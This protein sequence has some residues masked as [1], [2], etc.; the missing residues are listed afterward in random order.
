MKKLI[1]VLFALVLFSPAVCRADDGGG[2]DKK[3][4]TR[5]EVTVF[6]KKLVAVLDAMGLPPAGFAQEKDDFN[7][8]TE[9]YKDGKGK[10]NGSHASATRR[11][12]IKGVKDAEKGNKQLGVDYQKKMM[13][14]QAKGDY[15]AIMALSQEMQQKVGKTALSGVQAQEDKKLPIEVQVGLNDSA[16]QTIDPDMVVFEKP[17]VIAIKTQVGEEGDPKITISVYFQ[18]VV[19]KDTKDLSRVEIKSGAVPAKTSVAS[20]VIQLEGPAADVE[21][22]AKR[23][24]TKAVLA[25]IDATVK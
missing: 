2:D 22:W 7:L 14:A 8:P 4:L 24:D 18:P 12:A 6:K 17:G 15:Q 10:L 1:P 21:A 20:V 9:W 16:Y 11:L 5:S 13:E 23:I 3:L 19:L 25:Q